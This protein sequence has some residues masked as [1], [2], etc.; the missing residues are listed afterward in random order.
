[1]IL[2][3]SETKIFNTRQVSLKEPSQKDISIGINVDLIT[4]DFEKKNNK[5]FKQGL[6]IPF[7][8]SLSDTRKLV[9]I[10][11]E[12]ISLELNLIAFQFLDS[13]RSEDSETRGLEI[14]SR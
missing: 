10:S 13:R 3:G 1:M 6:K 2:N 8:F 4:V 11:Q 14:G 5:R 9:L 7:F 12:K